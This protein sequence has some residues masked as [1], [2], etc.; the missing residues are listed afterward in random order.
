[1]M[2]RVVIRETIATTETTENI[3]YEDTELSAIP[4]RGEYWQVK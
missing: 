1:M 4:D 2:Q 3:S